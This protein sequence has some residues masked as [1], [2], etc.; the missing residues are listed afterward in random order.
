VC[1][2]RDLV[3]G[4]N[5]ADEMLYEAKRARLRSGTTPV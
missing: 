1:S 4:L 2:G 3:F 5:R